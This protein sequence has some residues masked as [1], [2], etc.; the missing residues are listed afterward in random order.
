MNT[1]TET[2]ERDLLR[3]L[4]KL[5]HDCNKIPGVMAELSLIQQRLLARSPQP[6]DLASIKET[7]GTLAG[8]IGNAT[9]T[10]HEIY[11]DLNERTT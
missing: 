6:F 4:V 7:L 3:Q 8:V 1:S 9:N 5:Q 10:A 2:T 11:L